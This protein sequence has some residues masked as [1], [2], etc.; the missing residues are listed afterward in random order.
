MLRGA[1]AHAGCPGEGVPLFDEVIQAV[2]GPHGPQALR[3]I[4]V[5]LGARPLD[6]PLKGVGIPAWV[7]P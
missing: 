7:E 1:L 2:G 4:A 3:Q 5:L 6:F